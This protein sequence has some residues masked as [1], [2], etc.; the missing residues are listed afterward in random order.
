MTHIIVPRV[1]PVKYYGLRLF[2]IVFGCLLIWGA[3]ELGYQQFQ[4][5]LIA[6][7]GGR[8]SLLTQVQNLQY[9]VKELEETNQQLERQLQ[10]EKESAQILKDT[11]Y[12]DQEKI[13]VLEKDL[14]FYKAM[15]SPA[16]DEDTIYVQ[17]FEVKNLEKSFRYQFK[18]II[19]QKVKK[20]NYATGK[21]KVLLKGV[22]GEEPKILALDKVVEDKELSFKF[23]FKFF[24]TF[25]GYFTL[26]EDMKPETISIMIDA[27]TPKKLV[28]YNDLPW[29]A[30]GG[31]I[32]VGE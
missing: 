13:A 23:K 10:L 7:K 4:K 3:F 28:E 14:A 11:L 17:L 25:K 19:A 1:H 6:G 2:W 27:K 31:I 22:Q 5:D 8:D 32:D 15:L 16:V 26:P 20:R 21:V 29:S 30:N 24:Q 12:Q 18:L 9:E